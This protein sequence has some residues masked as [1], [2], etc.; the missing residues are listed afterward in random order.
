MMFAGLYTVCLY[1]YIL[2]SNVYLYV[3]VYAN[4]CKHSV[5]SLATHTAEKAYK[6][7]YVH[8]DTCSLA[9]LSACNEG[10]DP[11]GPS[12]NMIAFRA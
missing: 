6:Y 5:A 4:T 8:N 7:A 1:G 3:Y 10:A 12:M 9:L 2:G 11:I